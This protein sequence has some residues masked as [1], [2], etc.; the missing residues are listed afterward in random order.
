MSRLLGTFVGLV[1]IVL[2][3]PDAHA[4][5][6]GDA[7]SIASDSAT[8]GGTREVARNANV[9]IHTLRLPSGTLVREYVFR[10]KVFAIAWGGPVIPDL[11]RLLGSYFEAY[12]N[13]PRGRGTGHHHMRVVATP[14]WVVQSGGHQDAFVGRAWLP[15]V[16]PPSF[17]LA[18]VRAW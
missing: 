12:V 16:L 14:D 11:R 3:A 13:D 9:E 2:G 17:D 10:G 7:A 5:L 15:N 4:A 6:G 1:A 18:T 8:F